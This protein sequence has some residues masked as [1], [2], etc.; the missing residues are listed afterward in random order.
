M[1]YNAEYNAFAAYDIVNVYDFM[2]GVGQVST[3]GRLNLENDKSAVDTYELSFSLPLLILAV[4]LFVADVII[5]K[6]K[7][8]DILGLFRKN[9]KEGERI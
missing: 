1:P 2:S 9:A 5:R 3:D 7:W 8:K 4:V 6:F